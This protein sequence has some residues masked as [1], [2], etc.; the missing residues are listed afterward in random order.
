MR[1]AALFERGLVEEVRSLW[2]RGYGPQLP[3]LRS[4]GYLE[5]GRV[6]T[7]ERSTAEAI[8]DVI[9]ST[10][11]FAKRQ[12]TWFRAEHDAVRVHPDDD[13]ARIVEEIRAFLDPPTRVAL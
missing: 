13:R 7:G 4:I 3:A 11:R 6:L 8:E 5:A 1:S 10:M 9:R 12:R 2:Q